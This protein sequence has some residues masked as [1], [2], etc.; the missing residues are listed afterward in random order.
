MKSLRLRKRKCRFGGRVGEKK[1]KYQKASKIVICS[2]DKNVENTTEEVLIHDEQG[3]LG[4]EEFT[5]NVAL[6]ETIE[7]VSDDEEETSQERK[8]TL[9]QHLTKADLKSI[10]DHQMLQDTVIHVFQE[11]IQCQYPETGGLQDPILGQS[12]T[13]STYCSKPF[14]QVLHD[15]N[16]HWV[17]IS[18]YDCEPGEVYYMDSFFRGRISDKVKQQICSILH[19]EKNCLRIK[20]LPVQQQT[21]GVDCGI[22]ALAF[23]LYYV[24][25][26]NYPLDVTFDQGVMRHH[27][28]RALSAN[29]LE[30]FPEVINKHGRK[31][32][33]KEFELQLYCNWRMCWVPSFCRY[34]TVCFTCKPQALISKVVLTG[35]ET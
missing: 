18:T 27:L 11:M 3:Q 29:R 20:V 26:K 6:S 13:F 8:F 12:L 34:V 24:Q 9:R 33:Q 31:C 10:S 15:G 22:Y 2:A 35:Q 30:E 32:I 28:L 17:A 16:N 23:I 14:V 1:D 4:T 25:N 7:I 19:S 21:N 5:A